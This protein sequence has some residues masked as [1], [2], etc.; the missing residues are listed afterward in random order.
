MKILGRVGSS[1]EIDFKKVYIHVKSRKLISIPYW[2]PSQYPK[3]SW[4]DLKLIKDRKL[5]SRASSN[6][7]NP[8]LGNSISELLIIVFQCRHIISKRK[9][10]SMFSE[11]QLGTSPEILTLF[12]NLPSFYE[13]KPLKHCHRMTPRTMNCYESSCIQPHEAKLTENRSSKNQFSTFKDT[14]PN[15]D[16]STFYNFLEIEF[17]GSSLMIRNDIT[18]F[19]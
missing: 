5:I 3:M 17:E 6:S 8:F 11:D 15:P 10:P 19:A 13:F 14:T 9:S 18:R 7:T 4:K 12:E 2:L 1:V 16:M